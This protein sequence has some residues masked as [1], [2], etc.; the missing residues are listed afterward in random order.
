MT[1]AQ[2]FRAV[3]GAASDTALRQLAADYA[4]ALRENADANNLA[5]TALRAPSRSPF[6]PAA[7]LNHDTAAALS[8]WAG[9]KST[10]PV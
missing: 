4:A 9:A 7:P 6:Q 8:A 2:E 5:F 3:A 1:A 10:S